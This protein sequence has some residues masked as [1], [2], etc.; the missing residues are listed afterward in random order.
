MKNKALRS[1]VVALPKDALEGAHADTVAPVPTLLDAQRYVGLLYADNGFD[2]AD[3]TALVQQELFGRTLALPP[4][5]GRPLG[6]AGQRKMIGAMREQ[7]AAPLAGP[8]VGAMVLLSRTMTDGALV[9][10]LGT[11]FEGMYTWWVL[12]NVRD[13]GGVHLQRL[14]DVLRIYRLEGY[15][16]C[17]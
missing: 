6:A 5:A 9:W 2:C 16:E 10:H 12:H 4:Q 1:T 11:V 17:L 13:S 3:L 7:L 8:R 15:Y 14:E